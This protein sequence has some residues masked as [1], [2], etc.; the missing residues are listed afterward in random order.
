MP[1]TEIGS[2]PFPRLCVLLP[3]TAWVM[4]SKTEK[5]FRRSLYKRVQGY[6]NY[7]LH[8]C[9]VYVYQ[10]H[11]VPSSHSSRAPVAVGATD[12]TDRS[13]SARQ[14]G[15]RRTALQEDIED[16]FPLLILYFNLEIG[17]VVRARARLC[18]MIC[19]KLGQY[20]VKAM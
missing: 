6:T 18:N 16:L 3:G 8:A 11:C 12:A 7:V 17:K 1:N 2:I 4:L 13:P 15:R 19:N 14:E 9:H 5:L 20:Y 10:P